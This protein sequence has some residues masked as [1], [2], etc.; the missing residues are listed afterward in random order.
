MRG[1]V[2]YSPQSKFKDNTEINVRGTGFLRFAAEVY[3]NP[4]GDVANRV[5]GRVRYFL[6][7]KEAEKKYHFAQVQFG[8]SVLLSK[9]IGENK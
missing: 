7:T 5:F 8:Y 1:M 6:P 9:L 3:W 2:Q 4:F